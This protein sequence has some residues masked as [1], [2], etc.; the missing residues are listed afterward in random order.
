MEVFSGGCVYEYE[1]EANNWGLV[2]IFPDRRDEIGLAGRHESHDLKLEHYT[3]ETT[4]G[5]LYV[6]KEFDNYKARL[7]ETK[8]VVPNAEWESVAS[9]SN[10]SQPSQQWTIP[11]SCVDWAAIEGGLATS[12]G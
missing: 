3:R 2:K 6:F 1:Q 4:L 5:T 7:A 11:E 8:D 12:N 9:Q 10:Q